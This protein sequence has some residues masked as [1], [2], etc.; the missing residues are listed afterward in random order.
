MS[1]RTV[2]IELD[3]LSVPSRLEAGKAYYVE[4]LQKQKY[5]QDHVEVAVTKKQLSTALYVTGD[6]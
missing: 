5:N 1:G 4:V 3:F 2:I 6:L